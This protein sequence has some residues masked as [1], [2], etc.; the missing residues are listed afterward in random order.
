MAMKGN[1]VVGQS[2][3]PTAVINNSL[4][5]VVRE[6]L[7][8]EDSIDCVFGMLHGIR[9]VLR[10]EIIDLRAESLDTLDSLRDTPS[11]ALGTVRYKVTD[12]DYDR[13]IDVF[14][15]YEI[16]YFFYIGGNDSMDTTFKIRQAAQEANYEVYAIGVPKT[17]DN[18][19]ALTDHCPGYGSAA[20]FVAASIRNTGT[21]T[22]S[23]GESGPLKMMEIMGRNAGW[24]TAAA[25]LAKTR[26][27]EPPHLIY[28]PERG[29]SLEQ[30]VEDVR[31]C[32]DEYGFCVAAVSE[33]LK[34]EKG[35]DLVKQQGQ[36]HVDAFG[37]AAKGP[38]V[39]CIAEV[40]GEA[41]GKRVRVDK[42][43]YLQ[44][45]YAEL[46]SPVDREEAYQVG[47]EAV[48][49]ACD[50]KSGHMV[51]LVREPGPKY[52][53]SMGLAPLDQ[54]ANAERM[55]P[56]EYMNEAGN[57]VT[58]AFIEYARPLIGGRLQARGRLQAVRIDKR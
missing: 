22:W 50:G 49:A 29:V 11:S 19:L 16:R 35:E 18:D 28:V 15:K 25:A 30:I 9:G 53:C 48:R 23:M 58:D 13:L 24:L 2:G 34:D 37:H 33:G 45:S 4:V 5:G 12:D 6:A 7:E 8:R 38:V 54:V 10:E 31:N 52:R 47:R 36:V 1:M 3:G 40:V 21:D 17:V 46:Q 55:L 42:P 39:D 26:P 14:K 43:G 27:E 41:I 44:R 51:T 20:R 56:D 57:F 32:Y